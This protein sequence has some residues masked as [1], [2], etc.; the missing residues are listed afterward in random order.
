MTM[1]G[2]VG[3][4]YYF[5][6]QISSYAKTWQSGTR[7]NSYYYAIEICLLGIS[8]SKRRNIIGTGGSAIDSQ[9]FGP[10]TSWILL[11]LL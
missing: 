4:Q 1:N 7:K 5:F 10:I 2:A 9:L 3:I 11:K 8:M 6:Q